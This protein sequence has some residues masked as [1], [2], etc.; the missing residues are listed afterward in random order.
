MILKICLEITTFRY[1][2]VHSGLFCSS[3]IVFCLQCFGQEYWVFYGVI[4]SFQSKG[5]RLDPFS[6]LP[7]SQQYPVI[8]LSCE[9]LFTFCSLKQHNCVC[10]YIYIYIYIY[11]LPILELLF[12]CYLELGFLKIVVSD[13]RF[14]GLCL[15]SMSSMMSY[16]WARNRGILNWIPSVWRI[17]FVL[18]HPLVSGSFYSLYLFPLIPRLFV[19]EEERGL[20]NLPFLNHW[21]KNLG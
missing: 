19:E 16:I 10:V 8:P 20:R 21:R 15:D 9:I 13:S 14:R 2:S 5:K 4:L 11:S 7:L 12:H 18:E 3:F 1:V 17:N 6:C